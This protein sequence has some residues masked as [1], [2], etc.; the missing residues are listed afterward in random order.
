MDE[1]E[2]YMQGKGI[3]AKL[4]KHIEKYGKEKGVELLFWKKL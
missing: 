3:G 2:Q 1:G 4:L